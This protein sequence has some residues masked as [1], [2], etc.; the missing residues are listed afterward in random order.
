MALFRRGR[1]AAPDEER[2]AEL[3]MLSAGDAD[4]LRALV[5][6][7]FAELGDEVTVHADHVA[8]ADGT[9]YGLW[10]VAAACAVE[11]RRGWPELVRR[12]VRNVH[13]AR[14]GLPAGDDTGVPYVRLYADDPKLTEHPQAAFAP[15]LVQLLALDQ[16]E[17]VL[18]MNRETVDRLGGW[19]TLYEQG[20]A[21]LRRLPLGTH[22]VV[23]PEGG[24][25]HLVE[26]ESVHTASRALVLGDVARQAG[27]D[28]AGEG[29]WV[30]SVPTRHLLMW[31]VIRDLTAIPSIQGM[32][33]LTLRAFGDAV[34]QLS[35][36]VYWWDGSGY[37]QLT[38]FD[39]GT[40]TITADPD[41]TDVLNRLA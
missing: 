6:E 1:G 7:A 40:P 14:T 35:P 28:L 17:T 31:H 12:H 10:N 4:A 3:T 37:R 15:G 22:T 19:Q 38:S 27:D 32:A 29:G 26:D 24:A 8:G 23:R 30:L 18:A 9:Q 25:F 2:D 20:L 13:A 41:L 16:P 39:G 34:G 5:R 33:Q 36:H 11:P 21:N